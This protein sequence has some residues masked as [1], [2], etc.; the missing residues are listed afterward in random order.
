M[1]GFFQNLEQLIIPRRAATILGRTSPCAVKADR[2]RQPFLLLLVCH[3]RDFMVPAVA[4]V[5]FITNPVT[6]L[7]EKAF[8][9]ALGFILS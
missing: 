1:F 2:L 6:W 9:L 5:I 3:Q 7:F 4:K 8:Q